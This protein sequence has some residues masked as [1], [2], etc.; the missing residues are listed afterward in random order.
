MALFSREVRNDD[1]EDLAT[2]RADR[3]GGASVVNFDMPEFGAMLTVDEAERLANALL[4][5][6]AVLKGS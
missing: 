6:V 2:V 3:V 1:G 5:A 4:S